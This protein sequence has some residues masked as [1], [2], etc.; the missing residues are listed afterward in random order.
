M[1]YSF[2]GIHKSRRFYDLIHTFPK[3]RVATIYCGLLI[4][5]SSRYVVLQYTISKHCIL[6]VPIQNH[7]TIIYQIHKISNA[8]SNWE[9]DSGYGDL[10]NYGDR[11]KLKILWLNLKLSSR[12]SN[13]YYI[14]VGWS[15]IWAEMSCLNSTVVFFIDF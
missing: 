1:I 8:N 11:R 4:P 15:P 14:V 10:I 12:F 3:L 9:T 5:L 7:L 13:P 2:S 6:Q